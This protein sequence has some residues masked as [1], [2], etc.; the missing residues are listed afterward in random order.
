MSVIPH[1]NLRDAMLALQ[2]RAGINPSSTVYKEA[3]VNG[4]NSIGL[5]EAIHA[6]QVVSGIRCE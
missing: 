3:D 6:L 1:M 5:E 4:D 2:V